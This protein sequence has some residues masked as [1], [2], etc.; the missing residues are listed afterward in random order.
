MEKPIDSSK[1]L[2]EVDRW[3]T[4]P[5]AARSCSLLVLGCPEVLFSTVGFLHQVLPAAIRR[6][7]HRDSCTPYGDDLHSVGQ[8]NTARV[9]TLQ[10]LVQHMVR[11]R[12]HVQPWNEVNATVNRQTV[13]SLLCHV[14][15]VRR[16][17]DAN[18]GQEAYSF[19]CELQQQHPKF[20][21]LPI[22][23]WDPRQGR[24]LHPTSLAELPS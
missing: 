22:F 11:H 21:A 19:L 1:F 4:A 8:D 14:D 3:Q 15:H 7:D 18:I 17:F 23:V 13:V 20:A 10:D 2:V 16:N 5:N 6:L 9:D 12:E 24:L